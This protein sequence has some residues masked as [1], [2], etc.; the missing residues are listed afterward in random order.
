MTCITPNYRNAWRTVIPSY[1]Q[2][3]KQLGVLD[4]KYGTWTGGRD[5]PAKHVFDVTMPEL[6]RP[7]ARHEAERRG[8]VHVEVEFAALND[9]S[10]EEFVRGY[11]TTCW[12]IP[13]MDQMP[14][15]LIGLAA[16]RV[17]RYP[18]PRDRPDPN[19]EPTYAG[20]FG[21]ANV[22]D[23][24]SWFY[25]QWWLPGNRKENWHLFRQPGGFHPDAE[26]LENLRK[27]NPRY[28]EVMAADMERWAVRR[29]IDCRP[30]YSRHGLPVHEDFDDDRHVSKTRIEVDPYQEILIGADGGGNT[31]MPAASFMQRAID[32][33]WT[34]L[35]E[36][37]PDQNTS[38]QEFGFRIQQ[39]LNTRIKRARGAVIIGDPAML[40]VSPLSPHTYAQQL[41]ISSGVE[42]RPAPSQDPKLRRGGLKAVLRRSPRQ[43]PDFLVDPE[44]PSLIRA[45][46]GGFRYNKKDKEK[47]DLRPVKNQHSHIA[48]SCEYGVLGGEGL[49]GFFSPVAGGGLLNDSADLY[50]EPIL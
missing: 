36:F 40:I 1:Q 8:Q 29:F 28:Y 20:V 2:V 49:T 24:D 14:R 32:G 38:A 37:A 48:E 45:L 7:H 15:D 23:I 18:M 47:G 39:I 41:Q 19:G 16:N 34:V 46:A 6:R 3:V 26:N 25:E 10:L 27:I 50:P 21:D 4:P 5:S 17:G 12:W 30:G 33:R 31:N 35:A 22:P 9:T 42:V 11:Q 43:R 13:E 44:C